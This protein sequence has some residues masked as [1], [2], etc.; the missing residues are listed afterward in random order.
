MPSPIR[1]ATTA[2]GSSPTSRSSRAGGDLTPGSPIRL[3]DAANHMAVVQGTDRAGMRLQVTVAVTRRGSWRRQASSAALGRPAWRSRRTRRSAAAIGE[4]L[5][6]RCAGLTSYDSATRSSRGRG[7]AKDSEYA[8]M[9]DDAGDV[10][11]SRARRS[12]PAR[13]IAYRRSRRSGGPLRDPEGAEPGRV[14][15]RLRL[16]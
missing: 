7:D 2:G 6:A 11:S 4:E 15:E 9:L 10:V 13:R 12:D 1:T 14:D 3:E 8:E 16:D 5:P